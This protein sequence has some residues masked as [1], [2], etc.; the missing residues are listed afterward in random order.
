MEREKGVITD[1]VASSAGLLGPFVA[2]R[3]DRRTG[4]AGL[5]SQGREY[6][7]QEKQA[8][9]RMNKDARPAS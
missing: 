3:L 8:I 1:V 5:R 9:I 6:D 4:V 2:E 7:L